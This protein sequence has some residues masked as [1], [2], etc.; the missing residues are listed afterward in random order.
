MTCSAYFAPRPPVLI[1]L[2]GSDSA[3]DAENYEIIFD[4]TIVDAP[5]GTKVGHTLGTGEYNI[6]VTLDDQ[7]LVQ[8]AA[9]ATPYCVEPWTYLNAALTDLGFSL[10]TGRC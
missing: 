4:V 8:C 3:G 2:T 1:S 10:L 9:A 6:T 7:Y 5:A